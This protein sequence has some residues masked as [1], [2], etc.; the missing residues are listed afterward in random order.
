MVGVR[1]IRCA[2]TRNFI[3]GL[4]LCFEFLIGSSNDKITQIIMHLLVSLTVVLWQLKFLLY[5]VFSLFLFSLS[6]RICILNC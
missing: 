5:L 2:S 1:N 3:Y 4:P 6:C